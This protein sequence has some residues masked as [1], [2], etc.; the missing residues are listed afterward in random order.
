MT[1]NTTTNTTTAPVKPTPPAQAVDCRLLNNSQ[2]AGR[3]D[4]RVQTVEKG[5]AVEVACNYDAVI[6]SVDELLKPVYG[7]TDLYLYNPAG[8]DGCKEF[9]LPIVFRSCMPLFGVEFS[10]AMVEAE[11][12]LLNIT[13]LSGFLHSNGNLMLQGG[14]SAV[15]SNVLQTYINQSFLELNL[16]SGADIVPDRIET[17][18]AILIAAS[19][20]VLFSSL[21]L[22]MAGCRRQ[23]DRSDDLSVI[24]RTVGTAGDLG[25]RFIPPSP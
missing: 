11:V 9:W 18:L 7:D 17:I 13:E 4:L 25:E 12:N 15:A 21:C 19:L 2:W 5:Q 22:C 24:A 3:A 1:G 20:V 8:G 16:T 23:C 6:K 14:A 10:D